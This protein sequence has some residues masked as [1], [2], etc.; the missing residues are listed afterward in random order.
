VPQIEIM[1]EQERSNAWEFLVQ[2]L[3]DAGELRRHQLI[4]S[5]ADYNLWSPDGSDEPARVAEGVM[6]FV[7]A[8]MPAAQVGERFDASRIRRQFPNADRDIPRMIPR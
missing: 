8:Q 2:V 3:D 4:L 6:A 1:S 5:W 7:L